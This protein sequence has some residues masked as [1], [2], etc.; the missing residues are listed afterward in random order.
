[1]PS[2]YSYGTNIAATLEKYKS[3]GSFYGELRS[4]FLRR[5]ELMPRSTVNGDNWGCIYDHADILLARYKVGHMIGSHT[6]VF[7]RRRMEAKLM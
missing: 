7:L 2:Q 3:K 5:S 4:R 1:M 6:Y